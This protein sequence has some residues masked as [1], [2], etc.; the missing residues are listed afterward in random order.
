MKETM[1]ET[2]EVQQGLLAL[3]SIMNHNSHGHCDPSG[4]LDFHGMSPHGPHSL[5]VHSLCCTFYFFI[6]IY[7]CIFSYEVAL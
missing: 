7:P 5:L 1:K 6:K 4:E 2:S 3:S